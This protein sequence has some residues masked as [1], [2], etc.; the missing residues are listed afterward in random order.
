MGKPRLFVIAIILA[1]LLGYAPN[2][3]SAQEQERYFPE[4]GHYVRGE[5]LAFYNSAPDPVLLFGYP[6]TS[7]F[8]RADTNIVYQYFEKGVLELH[9]DQPAGSR[10]FLTPVGEYLHKQTNQQLPDPASGSCRYFPT[11]RSVCYSFLEFYDKYN[12]AVWFGNPISGLE[13]VQGR[14]VQYFQYARLDWR[15]E[16]PDDLKVGVGNLGNEYFSFI[17]ESPSVIVAE[18]TTG[19]AAIQGPLS[20]SVRAYPAQAV[21]G[22]SG[23]QTIFVNVRDQRGAEVPNA[24]VRLVV[25]MPDGRQVTFDI[26]EKTSDKGVV[27]F[28]FPFASPQIGVVEIWVDASRDGLTDTTATSF[29]LWW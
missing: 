16:Y 21:T 20:L 14:V 13:L 25:R 7:A 17:K 9:L 28:E 23:R 2:H 10:V 4:T 11:G 5:L 1:L 27:R 19:G 12:G 29:R 22:R 8:R 3:S 26:P 15:P 24:S 6:T 18:P